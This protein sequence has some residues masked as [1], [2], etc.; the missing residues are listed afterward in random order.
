[1]Y[2]TPSLV[3]EIHPRALAQFIETRRVR[4][5]RAQI[6]AMDPTMKEYMEKITSSMDE[7]C[8]ELCNNTAA[9]HANTA[10]IDDLL[11]WRPDL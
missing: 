2:L 7:F 9:V 8:L 3:S 10:K 11:S 6:E 5:A 1:M 4:Q